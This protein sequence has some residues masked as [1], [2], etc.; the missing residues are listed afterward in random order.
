MCLKRDMIETDRS[1]SI[2]WLKTDRVV[3][4]ASESG[5]K[6]FSPRST[7]KLDRNPWHS[8]VCVVTSTHA[9]TTHTD[10]QAKNCCLYTH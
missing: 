1:W 8:R 9:Y 7:R 4:S 3:W 5:R 6:R 2:Q 10:I